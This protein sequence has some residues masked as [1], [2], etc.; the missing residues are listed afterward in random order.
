MNPH[1]AAI[2]DR[3]KHRCEYC[4]APELV[5][6]FPFE[7][8]HI[9]PLSRQG[10][11][12]ETNL[13]LSCRSCNLRKGSRTGYLVPETKTEV[14]FFH[15]RKD[16]WIENFYAE[17]TSGKITGKTQIGTVTVQQL[18]INSSAQIMARQMWMRL[19]IFP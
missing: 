6:N 19:G 7:V 12:D 10:T 3:A 14:R 5:F 11:N 4:R 15:P 18:G 9:V 16:L 17:T 8:D 13:S 1:Y 2:S